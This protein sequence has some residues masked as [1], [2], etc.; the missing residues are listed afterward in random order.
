MKYKSL[1][2]N[3]GAVPRMLYSLDK[4][5]DFVVFNKKIVNVSQQ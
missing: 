3:F 1:R 5:E 4:T 2:H